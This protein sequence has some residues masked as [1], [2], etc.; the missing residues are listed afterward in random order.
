[1]IN[2]A[3]LLAG[4]G[5]N[6]LGCRCR[7]WSSDR[8]QISRGVQRIFGRLR[9]GKFQCDYDRYTY[10]VGRSELRWRR[11]DFYFGSTADSQPMPNWFVRLVTL[12]HVEGSEVLTFNY[13]DLIESSLRALV[14][15]SAE[16]HRA[17][18]VHIPG[19]IPPEL[20]RTGMR[21]ADESCETF[22]LRKLHGSI[23]WYG[24]QDSHDLY[25]LSIIRVDSQIPGWSNTDRPNMAYLRPF[26]LALSAASSSLC[27]YNIPVASDCQ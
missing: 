23:N 27:I 5:W 20:P 25:S 1:M 18:P 9:R 11:G 21:F 24:R 14:L 7:E 15:R 4:L 10:D 6:S 8:R 19:N 3:H 17:M 16:E 13:D 2:P 22:T 26:I 12:W